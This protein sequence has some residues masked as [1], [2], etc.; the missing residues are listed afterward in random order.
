MLILLNPVKLQLF[1]YGIAYVSL[2]QIYFMKALYTLSLFLFS[3]ICY[4]Q[5]S[6]SLHINKNKDFAKLKID[7]NFKNMS[8]TNK[9][10]SGN[11]I[12]E[13]DEHFDLLLQAYISQKKVQGFK[14]QLYAGNKKIDAL[15]MKADFMKKYEDQASPSIIYQQPNFKVRVGN[16]RNRLEATK[17]LELYKIDF[18]SA[19]IVKDAIESKE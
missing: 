17:N 8:L 14:I 3:I 7:S 2:E 9:V 19:F 11:L 15:K 6:D 4:S 1:F 16:Y 13:A 12:I 5:T 10:D 18:P